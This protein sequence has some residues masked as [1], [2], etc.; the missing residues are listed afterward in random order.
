MRDFELERYFSEWEF[1]AR[2]HMTAS[3]IES[4]SIADLLELASAADKE[5][6]HNQWLGY[7][8]TFGHPELLQEIAATYETATPSDILCFGG[9]EEGIYAAMRVLLDRGGR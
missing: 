7:T 1:S 6:F 5:A 4:M 8:E 2:H 9:A 3:D